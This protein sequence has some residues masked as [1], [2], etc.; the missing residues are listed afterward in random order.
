MHHQPFYSLVESICC[1]NVSL[2]LW[3]EW[4]LITLINIAYPFPENGK[5]NSQALYHA[6][7][8]SAIS[9]SKNISVQLIGTDGH[10]T[11]ST[12]SFSTN[13]ETG[14]RRQMS[15]Q[16]GALLVF[17]GIAFKCHSL[18]LSFLLSLPPL[19]ISISWFS[20]TFHKLKTKNLHTLRHRYDS[21]I[22][23]KY[24]LIS[25]SL[26]LF[27]NILGTIKRNQ[28]LTTWKTLW[29]LVKEHKL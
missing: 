19:P 16:G 22:F 23:K 24:A 7:E 11:D 13:Q 28:A 9:Y 20:W 14:A 12:V 17:A 8:V 2:L 4:A 6:A 18:S 10:S 29:G 3:I 26:F 27:P 5:Q 25:K 1:L 21:A 15:D